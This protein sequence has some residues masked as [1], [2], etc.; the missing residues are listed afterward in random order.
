[1]E[2]HDNDERLKRCFEEVGRRFRYD[3]VNAEFM[4]FNDFKVSWQRTYGWIDFRVSDYLQD[5][6]DDVL[7]SLADSI[8]KRI[9]GE[10]DSYSP[11]LYDWVTSPEFCASKQGLYL[12]RRCNLSR[13][14][15]GDYKNLRQS[16]DRLVG[17]GLLDYD[18]SITFSW[19]RD[20]YARKTGH[21]SVLMKVVEISRNLDSDDIPDFV[22]DYCMY[23]E[24]CHIAL[25][26]DPTGS[27][28]DD[29]YYGLE[30]KFPSKREAEQWLRRKSLHV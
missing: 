16:Y 29:A 7:M 24:L 23:H 14:A 13:S 22:L 4:A 28:H 9:M 21:C 12:L 17:A 26:F 8:F 19:T 18:P 10:D 20:R 25:G 1:M 2:I 15:E 27:M 11:N 5:A 6:P 30:N 3:S